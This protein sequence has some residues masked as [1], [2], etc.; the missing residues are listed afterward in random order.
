MAETRSRR[1]RSIPY[2]R[3]SFSL[4]IF[5]AFQR[6]LK[7]YSIRT[8]AGFQINS[9][10]DTQTQKCYIKRRANSATHSRARIW[11]LEPSVPARV[12][13]CSLAR[14]RAS[15]SQREHKGPGRRDGTQNIRNIQ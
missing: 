12:S 11:F 14:A 6:P 15:L 4:V 5:L 10:V 3:V 8:Q 9:I 1:N 2:T 13:L 7:Q